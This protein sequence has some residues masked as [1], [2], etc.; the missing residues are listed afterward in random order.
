MCLYNLIKTWFTT[1]DK[2][3]YIY[4]DDKYYIG[5]ANGSGK[6]REKKYIKK[7]LITG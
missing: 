2:E 6:R 5:Y 7:V 1:K 4:L 3:D